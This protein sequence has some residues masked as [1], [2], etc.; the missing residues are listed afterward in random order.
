MKWFEVAYEPLNWKRITI[1]GYWEDQG[2]RDLD[3]VVWY[4]RVIDVPASMTGTD[5][6]VKLGRIRNADE[7]FVN[8]QSVGKTTYE[9]PQL[10][11]TIPAGILQPGQNLF[12]VRVTNDNC[13]GG[14]IPDKPYLLRAAGQTID[15]K[16]DWDYKVGEA[17]APKRAYKSGINAQNQPAALY[18]GMIAPFT[19]FGIRGFLWY[20]GESNTSDPASYRRLLPNL[21]ADWHTHWGQGNIPFLIAQL[22]NFQEV[23]YL[24]AE[25]NWSLLQ[26]AQ[27][28]TALTTPNIGINIDLGEWN[29][30]HPGNKKPVGE[31][32]ALQALKLSY[33]YDTLVASGPI[34]HSHEIEDGKIILHFDH[35]GG[36]LVTNNGEDLAHCA[37][38]GADKKFIWAHSKIE[39]DTVVVRHEDVP[40]PVHVRYAWADNPD[41]AN[42][43]NADGLPASPFRTD[44]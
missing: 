36:G 30:I 24:P 8:G 28:Q 42:L 11:Y 20:Q 38:A 29:D 9:Y 34:Y 37:I 19:S 17:Y 33:G 31:R 43:G 4:R 18:N 41:F 35:V 13:K 16:G 39:G 22:P 12:V 15:L 32:L 23:D 3:G 6:V 5:T 14:F 21:I 44:R 40:L 2:V 7:L 25:S 27:L 10:N 26:E 1:P